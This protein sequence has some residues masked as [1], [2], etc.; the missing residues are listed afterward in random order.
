MLLKN[1]YRQTC[2]QGY[3]KRTEISFWKAKENNVI[4]GKS[5]HL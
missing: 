2:E 4:E 1:K 5:I 3:F